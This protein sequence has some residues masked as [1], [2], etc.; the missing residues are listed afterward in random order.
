MVNLTTI[1]TTVITDVTSYL[2]AV[3]NSGL[4]PTKV[5]TVYLD[6]ENDVWYVDDP[7]GKS[8]AQL[9]EAFA[10]LTFRRGLGP[11]PF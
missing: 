10:F 2:S 5:P 1:G 7:S 4:K 11:P 3:R 9:Q 6:S 8:P